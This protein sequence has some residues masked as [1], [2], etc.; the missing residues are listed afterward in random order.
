V[1][2]R[3]KPL[4]LIVLGAVGL[5]GAIILA[6]KQNGDGPATNVPAQAAS[7]RVLVVTTSLRYGEALILSGKED[8]DKG[9]RANA[10]FADWPK[11]HVPHGAITDPAAQVKP[12]TPDEDNSAEKVKADADKINKAAA[13]L[14][15]SV[16]EK[17]ALA[18][19]RIFIN[20]PVFASQI[21]VMQRPRGSRLCAVKALREHMKQ[22]LFDEQATQVDLKRKSASGHYDELWMEGL[23]VFGLGKLTDEN[24]VVACEFDKQELWILLPNAE[25][26]S[27]FRQESK[28]LL[29]LPR[30]AKSL[31]RPRLTGQSAPINESE[32][33][34]AID[35]MRTRKKMLE[36]VTID[37]DQGRFAE[38]C[39]ALAKCEEVKLLQSAQQSLFD[40]ILKEADTA[41]RAKNYDAALAA[42]A[43]FDAASAAFAR[44]TALR[45]R[46]EKLVSTRAHQDDYT[47]LLR[48]TPLAL[49]SGNLPRVEELLARIQMFALEQFVPD[50]AEQRKPATA[51]ADYAK[52]LA[53]RQTAFEKDVAHF[54]KMID[55]KILD[56]ARKTLASIRKK[57]PE[58]PDIKS[59]LEPKL[60]KAE[61]G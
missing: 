24:D 22:G 34:T 6:R 54:N 46:V 57:F 56:L 40:V 37:A 2:S 29:A 30:V 20:S 32:A 8:K 53:T 52:Q 28:N 27:L 45:K 11:A 33:R 44:A 41:S 59:K 58:H 42:L 3:T 10:R 15:K 36:S 7:V 9:E 31:D 47:S 17:K 14:L 48:D 4:I 12:K 43:R 39:A 51:H 13:D 35:E 38:V 5:C 50:S 23:P 19:T 16:K 49:E 1:S 26:E 25:M 61:N 21:N 55:R 60:R 18:R